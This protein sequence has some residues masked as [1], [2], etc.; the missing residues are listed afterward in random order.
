MTTLLKD[1]DGLLVSN[2]TNVRYLTG[3]SGANPHEREAYVL[4]TEKVMYLITHALNI[5]AAKKIVQS[6]KLQVQSKKIE[7]VEI[8][9]DKPLSAA[10]KEVLDSLMLS[11]MMRFGI[12]LPSLGT[13][14]LRDQHFGHCR[15]T[16]LRD[17]HRW[18]HRRQVRR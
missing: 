17:A 5:E 16:G 6:S 10:I 15:A 4:V 8:S 12:Y 7:V 14:H 11:L 3:F 1:I 18:P 2:Q 13:S 9:R